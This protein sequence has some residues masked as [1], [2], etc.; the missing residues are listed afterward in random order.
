[1]SWDGQLC[2]DARLV[3]GLARAAAAEGARIITRCRALAIAGDGAEVRDELTG[4]TFEIRARAVVNATGV[5]AGTLVPG[6]QVRPSLGTHII[7]PPEALGGLTAGLM[8]PIPGTIG[9]AVMA[10][11]QPDGLVYAGL[12][13]RPLD[14]PVPDVP[15][16][17]EADIAFLLDV[18]NTVLDQPLRRADVL[19]AYAGLRPLLS[20]RSDR[21]RRRRQDSGNDTDTDTADLSRRHALLTGPDG[22]VTIV[23][24][25]LTTYRRMAADAIDAVLQRTGLPAGPCR[26]RRLPLPGAGSPQRLAHVPAPRRLVARYGTEAPQVLAEAANQPWLLEPIADTSPVLGAELLWAI[27]HEGALDIDDLLDR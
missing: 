4:S 24:G 1:V 10:L 14:G 15:E 12:T 9:R 13:D 16:P 21:S 27:R 23:G 3:I 8:V 11:P 22:V 18:L 2:D 20:G 6:V 25:K 7:L 17:P 5:W 26:T 19:G